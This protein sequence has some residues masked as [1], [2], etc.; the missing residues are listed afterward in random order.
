[1]ETRRE[2]M[3]TTSF[4]ELAA[5]AWGLPGRVTVRGSAEG[6]LR[7]WK[8]RVESHEAETRI[9]ARERRGAQSSQIT[10]SHNGWGAV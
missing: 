3:A 5:R 1:M 8:W 7:L 10:R 2:V 4:V 6:F 9:P